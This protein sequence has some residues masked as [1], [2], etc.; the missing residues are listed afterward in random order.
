[1][2]EQFPDVK[3]EA[4]DFTFSGSHGR[5]HAVKAANVEQ[6]RFESALDALDA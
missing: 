4:G 2:I 1:M 6:K 3:R 5:R